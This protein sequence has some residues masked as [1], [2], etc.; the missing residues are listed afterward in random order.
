MAI[1]ILDFSRHGVFR[2]TGSVG[3]DEGCV[4]RTA[5][6]PE[7][8]PAGEGIVVVTSPRVRREVLELLDVAPTDD[9]ISGL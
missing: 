9:H 1:C 8:E 6:F 2:L 3:A 7:P 4:D 5:F